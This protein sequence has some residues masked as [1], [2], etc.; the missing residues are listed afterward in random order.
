M[1]TQNYA[2]HRRFVPMFHGLLGFLLLLTLIG[3]C[4]NLYMSVGDHQRLYSAS[5]IV[6]LTICGILL[7]W[8]TRTFSCKAQDRAIRAE[9]NLRHFVLT[10]KLLD[11]RIRLGQIVALRFAPDPEFVPLA[12]RAAE[13]NLP[14]DDIKRAIKVWRPDTDRV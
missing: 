13:E 5:L 11:P 10:G 1:A 14:S 8:F 2:N 9:E 6:V 3:S 4:V 12:R 7:F